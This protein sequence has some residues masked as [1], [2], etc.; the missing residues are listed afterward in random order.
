[1]DIIFC[2]NKFNVKW[3]HVSST[4]LNLVVMPFDRKM[5]SC[6]GWHRSF[7][8]EATRTGASMSSVTE[9]FLILVSSKKI[10]EAFN[11][12]SSLSKTSWGVAIKRALFRSNCINILLIQISPI[13][14]KHLGKINNTNFK[15][16]LWVDEKVWGP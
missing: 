8:N 11:D 12:L 6:N 16:L 10:L 15:H 14:W 13:Q 1:M 2:S 7:V 4:F 3:L 5:R 9:E